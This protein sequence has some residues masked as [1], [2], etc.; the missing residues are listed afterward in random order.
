MFQYHLTHKNK[1]KIVA[2]IKMAKHQEHL[3]LKF[4]WIDFILHMHKKIIFYSFCSF[5]S[6][7]HQKEDFIAIIHKSIQFT[8]Y[9]WNI[10]F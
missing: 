5:V 2:S 6:Y 10:F 8:Y 4:I 7:Y 3:L 9:L 1:T